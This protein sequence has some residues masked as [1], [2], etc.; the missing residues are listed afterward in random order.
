M[1]HL[2]QAMKKRDRQLYLRL[3]AAALEEGID[4]ADWVLDAAKRK[5]AAGKGG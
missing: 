3:R 1:P 2:D 4:T 5:L